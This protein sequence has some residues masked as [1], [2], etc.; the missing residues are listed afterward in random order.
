MKIYLGSVGIPPQAHTSNANILVR[1]FS[2]DA[3][4]LSFAAALVNN[5]MTAAQIVV[6]AFAGLVVD[7]STRRPDCPSV[8][9]RLFF[10]VGVGGIVLDLAAVALDV[11]VLRTGLFGAAGPADRPRDGDD[12]REPLVAAAAAADLPPPLTPD[13]AFRIANALDG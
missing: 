10:A 3:A 5:A 8:G 12:L 6:G 4:A 11:C 1:R 9:A 7:C 2:R 13:L